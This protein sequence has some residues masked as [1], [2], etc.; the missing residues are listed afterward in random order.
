MDG[1]RDQVVRQI[2]IAAVIDVTVNVK[3][4]ERGGARD[5]K[6]PRISCLREPFPDGGGERKSVSCVHFP[7]FDSV[8]IRENEPPALRVNQHPERTARDTDIA[9]A[10]DFIEAREENVHHLSRPGTDRDLL[11]VLRHTPDVDVLLCDDPEKPPV[12]R[13]L[14]SHTESLRVCDGS[15]LKEFEQN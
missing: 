3:H 1:E 12:E 13:F 8:L 5:S 15:L 14:P 10:D 4:A 9:I 7:D 6:D 2:E 11:I